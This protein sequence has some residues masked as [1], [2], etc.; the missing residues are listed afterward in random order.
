MHGYFSS[1]SEG[2]FPILPQKIKPL[3]ALRNVDMAAKFVPDYSKKYSISKYVFFSL[4]GYTDWFKTLKDEDVVLLT[5]DS[6]YE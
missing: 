3:F 5:L 1:G 6:L 4:S 2:E